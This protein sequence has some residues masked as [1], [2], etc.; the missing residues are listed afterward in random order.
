[1]G[2]CTELCR[3]WFKVF[4]NDRKA[5]VIILY[6]LPVMGWGLFREPKAPLFWSMPAVWEVCH[7]RAEA[8]RQSGKHS[9]WHRDGKIVLCVWPNTRAVLASGDQEKGLWA[10]HTSLVYST[11]LSFCTNLI[12][13]EFYWLWTPYL[14]PRTIFKTSAS[15]DLFLILNSYFVLIICIFMLGKDISL[16]W[17]K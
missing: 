14:K 4:S 5:G 13:I 7:E 2:P 6:V 1:M 9:I 17:K 16:W 15:Y 10:P 12:S 11:V 3:T 8:P